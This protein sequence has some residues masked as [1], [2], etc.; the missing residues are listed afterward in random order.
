MLMKT[1]CFVWRSLYSF[2]IPVVRKTAS[3]LSPMLGTDST[4]EHG[5][6]VANWARRMV[7]LKGPC[8]NMMTVDVEDYF[9]VEAFFSVIERKDWGSYACRV[10]KNTDQIL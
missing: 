3:R 8:Q 9:Q 5:E 4:A 7:S 1:S 10:E 2:T 6:P